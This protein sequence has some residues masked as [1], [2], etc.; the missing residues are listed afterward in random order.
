MRYFSIIHLRPGPLRQT[1]AW[2][3]DLAVLIEDSLPAGPEKSAALRKLLEAK[4]CAV[5]AALDLVPE[6]DR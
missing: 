5:R 1:S 2:F 6:A 3:A 4:D